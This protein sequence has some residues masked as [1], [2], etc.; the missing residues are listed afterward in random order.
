MFNFFSRREKH[1]IIIAMITAVVLTYA[2]KAG[3]IDQQ[4]INDWELVWLLFYVLPLGIYLVT[5][6]GS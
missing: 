1:V 4:I 5:D 2:I 3:H 6:H